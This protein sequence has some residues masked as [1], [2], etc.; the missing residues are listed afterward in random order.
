MLDE[1]ITATRK[2][3]YFASAAGVSKSS[4]TMIKKAI[5]LNQ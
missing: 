2:W 1:V 4:I 3:E 5:D